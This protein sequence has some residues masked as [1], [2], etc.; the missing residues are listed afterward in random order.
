M[1]KITQQ[2]AANAE[3]SASASEELSAQAATMKDIVGE[4]VA[5]VGG[6]TARAA[7]RKTAVH[8]QDDGYSALHAVAATTGSPATKTSRRKTSNAAS[9]EQAIPMNDGKAMDAFNN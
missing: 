3:E 5:L 1:D 2:N 9:A 7:T 4:L 6:S 8:A